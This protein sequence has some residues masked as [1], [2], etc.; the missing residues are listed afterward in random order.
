VC[1]AEDDEF[2]K[3]ERRRRNEGKAPTLMFPAEPGCFISAA[4][5]F[6]LP[7]PLSTVESRGG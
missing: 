1:E 6:F 7:P 4:F 3:G 5:S 2:R